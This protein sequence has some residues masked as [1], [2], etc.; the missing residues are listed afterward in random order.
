MEFS[1]SSDD[2]SLETLEIEHR[3]EADIPAVTAAPLRDNA[4]RDDLPKEEDDDDDSVE[5][6]LPANPT[7]DRRA[8][9]APKRAKKAPSKKAPA[10][11]K[12][13]KKKTQTKKKTGTGKK[14]AGKVSKKHPKK[15]SS[16]LKSLT[17][18]IAKQLAKALKFNL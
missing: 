12:K 5:G 9:M 11:P 10:A 1:E 16:T 18:G 2:E 13:T 6:L 14:K 4:D 17:S 15:L 7:I 3:E 8:N